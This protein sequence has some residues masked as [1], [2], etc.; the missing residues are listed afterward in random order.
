MEIVKM[1]HFLILTILV[2]LVYGNPETVQR[3]CEPIRIELCRGI[4][5]NETSMPNL[6]GHELQTDVS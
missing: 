1:K 6:V 3:T 2:V 4:G 5:Y